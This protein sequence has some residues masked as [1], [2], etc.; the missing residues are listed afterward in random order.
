[1]DV[2]ATIVPIFAMV[3]MG[4]LA[5]RQGFMPLAFFQPANRLVYYMAIPAF[6]FRSV[7]RASL[8]T[9][10]NGTVLLITLGAA[11]CAYGTAWL[12]T[13]FRKW[14]DGRASAFILCSGHGNQGY[15]GLPIAFYYMGQAGLAK[16]GILAGFL[17]IV[18]NLL[19]VLFLQAYAP[20]K[21]AT[22]LLRLKA[23]GAKLIANPIIVAAFLG[24]LASASGLRLPTVVLRFLDM[25]GGIAP[26]LALLLIGAS[27]SFDVLRKNIN[28]V[29][30]STGIKIVGMPAL[31]LLLCALWQV[32]ADDSLPGLILLSSPT[33]TVTFVMIK[34]MQADSEFA[35]AAISASTLLSAGTYLFWLTALSGV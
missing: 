1:M 4:W 26:P 8:T 22:G 18:Q 12:L 24:I 14:P 32:P 27:L 3:L 21:Q 23:V 2:A 19:S 34:E 31:G 9:Q 5:R 33:A 17:M 29:L 13:R 15:V 10:F 25:L 7:S 16:A 30:G 6:I 11:L 20:H 28:S 35:V